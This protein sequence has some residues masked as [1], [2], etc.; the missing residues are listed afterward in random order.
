MFDRKMLEIEKL[1]VLLFG[2]TVGTLASTP[3]RLAAF[4]YSSSWIENGYSISPF[5]LPLEAGVFVA[6]PYPLDGLFGVFDD[7]LP[8]GWGRLL[9]D[10]ML[11]EH[12][13]DPSSI[14]FLSRL[15][16]VGTSGAGALEYRPSIETNTG[17]SLNDLDAIAQDCAAVLARED[18]RNLDVLFEMAGSSGG[19]RPKVNYLIDGEE[20]I[21][22]FPSS[23]DSIDIGLHEFEMAKAAEKSGIAIPD[24]RLLPSGRC[25]GYFATK[26]FDRFINSD[27]SIGKKHMVSVAALLETSH[28]IPNL[29]YDLL[30][31]LALRLTGNQEE[32]KRVFDLM[33][34]NVVCGN[35]DDHSKNFTYIHDASNDSWTLSPAYDLTRNSGVNGERAT[36]VNG[37]GRDITREDIMEVAKR[38]GIDQREAG[39]SIDRIESAIAASSGEDGR[40]FHTMCSLATAMSDI[41]EKE[42]LTSHSTRARDEER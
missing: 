10:R 19:A 13:I 16:I 23:I 28:R 7:S 12:G 25:P 32:V 33:V 36:T 15:A 18:S 20:W 30:A 1:D 17:F 6:K 42:R 11:M 9:V 2:E 35:H 4:E 40:K 14:G 8:D 21:V 41:C 37:K 5:S 24:V 39:M 34:F 26:R 3:D 38:S 31:R 29:D 22:K 27:G